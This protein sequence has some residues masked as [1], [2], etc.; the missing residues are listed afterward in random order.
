WGAIVGS[1]F[2]GIVNAIIRPVLIILT[3]PLNIVTLGLFTLVINGFTLWLTAITVKG[4]DVTGFGA[5]I[6]SALV[7]SI[8]SF[9]ISYL[10]KDR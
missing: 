8:V 2:L 9:V 4:F 7:L 6:L 3:L 1:I 10:V 5:A